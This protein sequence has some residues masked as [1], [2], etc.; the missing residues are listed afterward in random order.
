MRPFSLLIKPA[1]AD[2]N[3]DCEY[4]FYTEKAALYPDNPRH[5]MS[6][7]TLEQMVRN[8]FAAPQQEFAFGWQGGEP[9]LMGQKFFERAVELQRRYAPPG[10]TV[11]NGLQTN[12]TLIDDEFAAWLAANRFLV[13]ISIDGP[14]EVHDRYRKTRAG[15]G[16]HARVMR[17][18]DALKR[19]GVEYNV[20]ALVTQANV[21][22]PAAL[23]EYLKGL[24]AS[25]HQYIPCVETDEAGE[26]TDYSVSGD[27]WGRFLSG[28]FDAWAPADAAEVSI[29]FFDSVLTKML[30]GHATVCYMGKDCRHY[31]VVEHSGDIYPCDFYV[32]PA[33]KLGNVA[34]D[35]FVE[36]WRSPAYREFGREKR[37]WSKSCEGCPYLAYCAGDCPK[38]RL[39]G[40]NGGGDVA[41]PAA[42]DSSPGAAGEAGAP[43]VLCAGWKQFYAHALPRFEE[44]ATEFRAGRLRRGEGP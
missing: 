23:Y 20:L 32:E 30:N 39:E 9:T 5:R 33:R 24:G 2:C 26:L 11:S 1:S 12:G 19:H 16:S 27:D 35:A 21:R 44:L 8:F 28:L 15:G 38:M 13:G 7:E 29:R 42:A 36:L 22:E 17:G 10:S 6:E 43:S 40:D 4:C 3:L 34:D 41:K 14:A 37:R 25:H 31:F 18:L